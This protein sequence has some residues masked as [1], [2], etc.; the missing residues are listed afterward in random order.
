MTK[1]NELK[2]DPTFSE[3]DRT[4]LELKIR[5]TRMIIKKYHDSKKKEENGNKKISN[6]SAKR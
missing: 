5:N 3:D 6:N 1:W 4:D 2:N